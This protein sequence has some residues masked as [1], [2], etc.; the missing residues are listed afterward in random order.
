M[1]VMQLSINSGNTYPPEVMSQYNKQKLATP[2]TAE[3]PIP[4]DT[5][6]SAVPTTTSS[7][8]PVSNW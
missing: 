3:V 6:V 8:I 5:K 7:G 4:T 1:S 2:A